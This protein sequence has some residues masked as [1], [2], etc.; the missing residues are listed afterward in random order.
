LVSLGQGGHIGRFRVTGVYPPYRVGRSAEITIS[1]LTGY[2]A[3]R[4]IRHFPLSSRPIG[5]KLSD[6]ERFKETL[7]WELPVEPG[8]GPTPSIPESPPPA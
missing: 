2:P 7:L 3:V 4:K 8:S 5:R 6:T 1:G